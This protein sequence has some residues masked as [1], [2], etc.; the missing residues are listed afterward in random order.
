V[1][2]ELNGGFGILVKYGLYSPL[3]EVNLHFIYANI[4]LKIS[5]M[6]FISTLDYFY[7]IVYV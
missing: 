7:L 6:I 1:A 4:E 3:F 2:D 5:C